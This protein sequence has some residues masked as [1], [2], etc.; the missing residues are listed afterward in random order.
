MKGITVPYLASAK[1][2][3]VVTEYNY[4][5][6]SV[7][8]Y[9]EPRESETEKAFTQKIIEGLIKQ[10][11]TQ[12]STALFKK[13][14]YINTRSQQLENSFALSGGEKGKEAE[15]G[16][17]KRELLELDDIIGKGK[18]FRNYEFRISNDIRNIR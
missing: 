7:L 6:H 17:I 3:V 16:T 2:K 5:D 4:K 10:G 9:V 18:G 14:L 13:K 12:I 15:K 11:Y 8:F 1:L